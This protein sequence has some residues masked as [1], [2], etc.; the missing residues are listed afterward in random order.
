[1]ELLAGFSQWANNIL[2]ETCPQWLWTGKIIGNIVQK[3]NKHNNKNKE[4]QCS[5]PVIEKH[6]HPTPNLSTIRM[7][8]PSVL[9]II[10]WESL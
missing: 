3:T 5:Q 6:R 4:I 2:Y 10:W 8:H 1:M 9:Q 7:L